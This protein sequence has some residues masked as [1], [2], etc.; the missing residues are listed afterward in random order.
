[1]TPNRTANCL[2]FSLIEL[3]V[4]ISIISV[5]IALVLP[6][7]KQ[8]RATARQ[9]ACG[10]N[11]RQ[12]ATVWSIY[13]NQDFRGQVPPAVSLP[14]PFDARPADQIT[15]MQCFASYI[16]D[17]KAWQCPSDDARYF[18]DRGTSYEYPLALLLAFPNSDELLTLAKQSASIVPIVQDAASF[19]AER[20]DS[21]TQAAFLDEHVG[22][23]D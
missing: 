16:P 2:A 3:L 13:H 15:L 1:M 21:G 7:L 5:V 8:A 6:A 19:H 9:T 23:M 4:V 14:D 18:E 11:L 22:W 12:I 10:S 17:T 20:A